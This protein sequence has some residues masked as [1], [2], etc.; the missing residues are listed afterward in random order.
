MT[1]NI[2][3]LLILFCVTCFSDFV[4]AAPDNYFDT[5]K[6]KKFYEEATALYQKIERESAFT[7]QVNGVSIGYLDFGPKE[8]M[9]LI[10][11]HGP[12]GT[13]YE[14]LNVRDGLI[15]AGYRVIAI[16]VRGHGKTRIT[17]Y[18]I[19]VYD[20]AD[21]IAGLMDY[22]HIS[23]AV[24]GGLVKGGWVAAAFYDDYP[25]RTLGLL[26][27]DG[28]SYSSIQ[29]QEEIRNKLVQ[30]KPIPFDT[31]VFR[32][33][34]D[35]TTRFSSRLEG[36]KVLWG[37]ISP[38]V[39]EEPRLERITELLSHF[40]Q[41]VDGQWIYHADIKRLI[42]GQTVSGADRLYN[43]LPLLQQSQE[44][45]LPSV[46]FRRLHI[47]MLIIDPVSRSI[48][49]TPVRHLNARLQAQ[50]PEFIVHEIYEYE[51]AHPDAH[52]YWPERFVA[53][54]EGLLKRVQAGLRN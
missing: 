15:K 5:A 7:A 26:L 54:A 27:E 34:F 43:T 2:T 22:L 41:N 37:G 6:G 36:A 19:S 11:V 38:F 25:Q 4:I 42:I 13:G 31:K 50:H 30:S 46:I 47:P 14:M 8:G 10:W 32:K 28:G 21:D 9:P 20:V 49:G 23:E 12:G 17:D 45:M 29:L 52:A 48:D 18:N 24:I 3:S 35:T 16:D 33:L 40:R 53:S 51:I 44:L 1:K 39:R